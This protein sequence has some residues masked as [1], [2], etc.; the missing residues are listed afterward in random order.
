MNTAAPT[1]SRRRQRGATH[2]HA[3]PPIGDAIDKAIAAAAHSFDRVPADLA[4]Q[5][6]HDHLERI[7]IGAGVALVDF[8]RQFGAIDDDILAHDQAF[9]H[10]PFERGQFQRQAVEFEQA[11]LRLEGESAAGNARRGVA[12]RAAHQR[13]QPHHQFL[14]AEGL[15]EI[16]VGAGLE[17]I[18]LV[19]PAVARCQNE[20]RQLPA[21]GA[22]GAQHLRAGDFRQ[23]EIEDGGI[24]EFGV[25]QM[26]AILAVGG[27]I[28]GEI[29]VA[30]RAGDFTRQ[31]SIV[32]DQQYLHR[33]T[34]LPAARG[35]GATLTQPEPFRSGWRR[36]RCVKSGHVFKRRKP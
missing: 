28:D 23:A 2:H 30:Q 27:D 1:S 25:A 36:G 31:Q 17:A 32:F 4:A 14:D 3:P 12:G 10:A 18:H 11:G 33:G 34:G 7:G 9:E 16:V 8:L 6:R 21:I 22:P 15:G 19:G 24:V 26:L 29:L 35:R 20:N 5:P 13:A